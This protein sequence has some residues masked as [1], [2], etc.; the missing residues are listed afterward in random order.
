VGDIEFN[1]VVA[2]VGWVALVLALVGAVAL[3]RRRQREALAFLLLP[4]LVLGGYFA[5]QLVFFERNLSPA[6]PLLLVL[7]GV[8][9][10]ALLGPLALRWRWIA[11]GGLGALVVA[12]C[13]G[14]PG[15]SSPMNFRHVVRTRA[16]LSTTPCG[17]NSPIAV[18]WMSRSLDPGW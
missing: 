17:R 7:A 5:T 2:T 3:W 18:G 1:Y 13:C 8:G 6:L 14:S 15:R 16:R 12:V 4:P 11:G 9:G 10:A